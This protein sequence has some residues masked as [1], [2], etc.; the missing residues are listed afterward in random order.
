MADK[1]KGLLAALQGDGQPQAA[2]LQRRLSAATDILE[3]KGPSDAPRPAATSFRPET[4]TT[5]ELDVPLERIH[6][7]PRGARRLYPDSVL[8]D[9]LES[10]RA[11][12]QKMAALARRHPTIPGDYILIEGE[13]RR[14]CLALLNKPRM[15]V[16]LDETI[17]TD[18]EMYRV[19]R[20]VNKHR[21]DGTC[22]D[23]AMAWRD[24]LDDRMVDDQDALAALVGVAKGTVSKTLAVLK[25]PPTYLD[26][27]KEYPAL[28]PLTIGYE[29]YQLSNLADPNRMLQLVEGVIAG[30]TDSGHLIRLRE[31]LS[32]GKERKSKERFRSYALAGDGLTS[33]SLKESDTGR[34]VLD[35]QFGDAGAREAFVD[36][37]RSMFAVKDSQAAK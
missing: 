5:F 26:R 10:I 12:G 9:T 17:T 8:A 33:G 1:R 3:R 4:G 13:C 31:S 23:D 34:L 16:T 18:L 7:N 30:T 11:E 35:I 21:S 14:R 29:L 6:S 20:L 32:A 37:M 25:I 15:K 19:S 36:K 28:F 22:L 27:M 24:L 2:Q